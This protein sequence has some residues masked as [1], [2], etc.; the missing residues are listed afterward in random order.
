[1]EADR[2]ELVSVEV[3]EEDS[4]SASDP[5]LAPVS[6]PKPLKTVNAFCPPQLTVPYPLHGVL[7]CDVDTWLEEG[8][9]D[10]Q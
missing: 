10:R 5:A 1:M 9:V 4:S 3:L 8:L 2:V 7:H 6:S